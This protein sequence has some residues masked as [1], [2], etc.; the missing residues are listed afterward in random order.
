MAMLARAL[1]VAA[2][3]RMAG[4]VLT[5]RLLSA[6]VAV[7]FLF[8]V[9]LFGEKGT[10]GG[11]VYGGV[12][13]IA[14]LLGA[15]EGRAMLRSVGSESVDPVLFGVAIFLPLNAWFL[16]NR[17]AGRPLFGEDG[18]LLLGVALMA[19][20]LI[21]I[22]RQRLENVLFDWATSLAFGLYIGGL[23]QFF[24]PLRDRPEGGYWVITVMGLNFICDTAAFF[25]GRAFGRTPLAPLISPKKSLEGALGGV[26]ASALVAAGWGALT[27]NSPLLLL[28]FGAA[29]GIAAVLGDLAESLLK[30]QT[31][32]K[33][34]GAFLPGHGGILDRMDSLLFTVPVGV[35]FLQAFGSR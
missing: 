3:R 12:L 8:A 31:G 1:P 33:D 16:V 9:A 32:T 17:Q 10:F 35:M 26:A 15:L 5:L 11:Y 7:P 19:S 20:L 14:A 2:A 23:L 4:A 18:F 28:G 30:R 27:G 29:I 24:A 34:S 6:A 13:A 22:R 25:V 21:P